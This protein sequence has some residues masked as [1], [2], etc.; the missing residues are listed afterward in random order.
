MTE[1]GVRAAEEESPTGVKR[2]PGRLGES[3]SSSRPVRQSEDRGY[4]PPPPPQAY[5]RAHRRCEYDHEESRVHE[6]EY[7]YALSSLP[8]HGY[9]G[10]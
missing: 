7:N 9:I 5:T 2:S 3:G 1:Q 6:L 4:R 10:R 8:S